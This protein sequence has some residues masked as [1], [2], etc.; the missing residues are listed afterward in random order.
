MRT[1]EFRYAVV[2][3]VTDT[4]ASGSDTAHWIF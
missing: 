1:G 2:T 3:G 4:G